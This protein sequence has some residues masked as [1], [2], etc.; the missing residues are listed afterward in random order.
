MKGMKKGS[1][2]GGMKKGGGSNLGVLSQY[3]TAIKVTGKPSKKP[4]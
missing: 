4:K 1:S 2:K 3:D